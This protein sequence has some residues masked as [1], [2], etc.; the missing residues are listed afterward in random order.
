MN[1]TMKIVKSYEESEKGVSETIEKEAE[2][3][4]GG[5]LGMYLGTV[6]ASLLG[7]ENESRC[8]QK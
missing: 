5:F 1:D 6:G 8:R 4:K 2:E 7:K 3:Q